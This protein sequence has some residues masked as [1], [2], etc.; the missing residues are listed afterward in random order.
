[1]HPTLSVVQNST[2]VQHLNAGSTDFQARRKGDAGYL[3]FR[4][5]SK[6][7]CIGL[8]ILDHWCIIA[9]AS[10]RGRDWLS[11]QEYVSLLRSARGTASRGWL[12]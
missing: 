4:F 8:E 2:Q 9:V 1:M 7:W 10:T 5:R 11:H 6:E 12:S 3:G